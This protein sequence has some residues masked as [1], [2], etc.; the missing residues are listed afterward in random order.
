MEGLCQ[1][2]SELVAVECLRL[3]SVGLNDLLGEVADED[4][5]AVV[6]KRKLEHLI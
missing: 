4:C 3:V 5:K 1:K 6:L 2:R